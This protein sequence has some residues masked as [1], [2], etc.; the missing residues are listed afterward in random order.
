VKPIRETTDTFIIRIRLETRE[1]KNAE[2]VWRGVI[3]HIEIEE[4]KKGE[5][6]VYFDNLDKLR[7]YFVRYLQKI[8][9]KIDNR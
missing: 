4:A 7:A 1:L 3:E 6:P 9:I 5:A 2:P 8:G